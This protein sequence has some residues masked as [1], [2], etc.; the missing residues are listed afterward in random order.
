MDQRK[1]DFSHMKTYG[2]VDIQIYIFLTSTLVGSEWSASCSGRYIPGR[3][4]PGIHWIGGWMGL[5]TSL[6]DMG[7]R[8]ILPLL[9]LELRPPRPPSP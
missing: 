9:E 6:D 4:T 5:R 1:V 3:N 7:R 8:K 2:G